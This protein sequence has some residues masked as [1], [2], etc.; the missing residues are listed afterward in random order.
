MFDIRSQRFDAAGAKVGSELTVSTV[1]A[2][3]QTDA[4][5]TAL[6]SG[7]YVVTWTEATG[8]T[9][10]FVV[11]ANVKAQIFEANGTRVGGEVTVNPATTDSQARPVIASLSTGGFVIVWQDISG[12]GDA[13]EYGIRAQLFDVTGAKVGDS[14]LVNTSTANTQDLPE[15]TALAAGGFLVTWTDEIGDGSENAVKAQAFN[16]DGT[17]GGEEITVNTVTSNDQFLSTVVQLS[18]GRVA[19]GWQDFS[20]QGGDPNSS[21]KGQLVA[22][23]SSATITGTANADTLN[24]TAANDA[25]EGLGGNDILNGLAG[26]DIL[27][28]GDGEDSLFGGIGADAIDG[29]SGRTIAE[30]GPGNDKFL[31]NFAVTGSGTSSYLGGEGI[32]ILDFSNV[33]TTLVFQSTSQFPDRVLVGNSFIGEV[34]D[35]VGGSGSD[36]FDMSK[37][38]GATTLRGR[39]GDDRFIGAFNAAETMYGGEGTDSFDTVNGFDRAFGEEGDDSFLVGAR[40]GGV[41]TTG[42]VD[43]GSGVDT[44]QFSVD[45]IV[46]LKTGTAASGD[47]TFT[48]HNIEVV[49]AAAFAGFSSTFYGTERNDTLVVNPLYSDASAGVVFYGREGDD[50]LIGGLGEDYLYGGTGNDV[51]RGGAARTVAEGNDG[52]DYFVVTGE[53]SSGPASSY[54]GG[55]GVDTL[56]LSGLSSNLSFNSN[57][58]GSNA[59]AVGNNFVSGVEAF[60]AGSGNDNIDL[61]HFTVGTGLYGGAGDD[62]IRGG[63]GIDRLEGD[64]GVDTLYGGNAN[65]FLRGG[66]GGDFLFGQEGA[67]A[68]IFDRGGATDTIGDF[69]IG[70]DKLDLSAFDFQSASEV[71]TYG[72]QSGANTVL[73][74]P[75]GETIVLLNV[76]LSQLSS[77]DFIV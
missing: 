7:R 56:D 24:G 41:P 23:F 47:S 60:I 25:I 12:Q 58:P 38:F 71:L 30:G 32:D 39:G 44:V 76:M 21:I 50:A 37:L 11:P 48:L 57:F 59:L 40:Y 73:W 43:G 62:M 52:H 9:T 1:A 17:K 15:V 64:N 55:E 6:P 26:D 2:V 27:V 74:L 18:S 54:A 33:S 49:L 65:D 77:T 51:I 63:A 10:G 66:N 35:F 3:Q 68:F 42:I 69:E 46:D 67:D 53:P 70:K 29:G 45:F 5:V 28:G 75:Q 36:T 34:E 4:A 19:F 13:S 72:Q 14:F 61:S 20:G 16:S 22:L 31:M 8:P